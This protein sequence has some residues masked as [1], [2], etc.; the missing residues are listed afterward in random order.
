MI[1]TVYSVVRCKDLDFEFLRCE[2]K[3]FKSLEE[4]M[5]YADRLNDES[6][7]NVFVTQMVELEL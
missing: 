1:M 2:S 5:L 6:N 7:R 4:A 3:A